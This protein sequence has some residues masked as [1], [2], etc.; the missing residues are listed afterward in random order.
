MS[1]DWRPTLPSNA[2]PPKALEMNA[3][4][5][6]LLAYRSRALVHQASMLMGALTCAPAC[7]AREA[8]AF[9]AQAAGGVECLV[10]ALATAPELAA[11]RRTIQRFDIALAAWRRSV[12][13]ASPVA[14]R[15][16]A[17]LLQQAAQ[18][19]TACLYVESL[20]TSETA[21]GQVTRAEL[22]ACPTPSPSP[23]SH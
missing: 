23:S 3:E 2:I 4:A 19:V 1:G 6:Y 8:A 11:H 12:A 10:E 7:D 5:W 21:R 17:A 22:M 9:A 13:D 20:C 15:Y 18:V 16:Q 14:H